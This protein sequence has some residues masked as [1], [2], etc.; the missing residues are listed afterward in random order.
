MISKEQNLLFKKYLILKKIDEGSF[1]SIYLGNNIKTNEK[2]A[3]KV[4]NRKKFK[5]LLEREAYI[6]FYLKGRGIPQIK[7]FGKTLE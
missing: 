5:P 1:G 7:T 2:V 6:L 4:E 3:I